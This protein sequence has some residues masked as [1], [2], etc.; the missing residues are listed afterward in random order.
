MDLVIF[1]LACFGA[2]TI[3]TYS[4]LLEPLRDFAAWVHQSVKDFLCCALCVSFWVG[5]I[6]SYTWSFLHPVTGGL[7]SCGACWVIHVILVRL[8]MKEL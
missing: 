4:K 5:F 7:V 1:I 3:I 8:G 2:T 6:L